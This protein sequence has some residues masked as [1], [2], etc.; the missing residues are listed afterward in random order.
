M[1]V[2][3][4]LILFKVDGPTQC[5][6][7]LQ[8]FSASQ[9]F[10]VFAFFIHPPRIF[11]NIGNIAFLSFNNSLNV[12]TDLSSTKSDAHS[13]RINRCR[14]FTKQRYFKCYASSIS[15]D[16]SSYVTP[17]PR[18][19]IDLSRCFDC[20]FREAAWLLYLWIVIASA[21]RRFLPT[22]HIGHPHWHYRIN[23]AIKFH[24]NF[25]IKF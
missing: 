21:V 2:I 22:I 6:L 10:I 3:L 14:L 23:V 13:V 1:R 5:W 8:P 15:D 18:M 20:E 19:W 12:E 17:G 11:V 24:K 7:T 9:I 16:I 4:I 25:G